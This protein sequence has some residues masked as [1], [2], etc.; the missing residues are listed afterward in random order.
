MQK[1]VTRKVRE[2]VVEDAVEGFYLLKSPTPRTTQNGKNYLTFRLADTSGEIE[3]IYWDYEG[4]LHDTCAGKP[5]KVRGTISEYNGKKQFN[6]IQIRAAKEDDPLDMNALIPTAPIDPKE[7]YSQLVSLLDTIQ[8]PE[9]KKLCVEMLARNQ[10]FIC[11]IP[12]AKSVHHSFRYGLLMHTYFMMCHADYMSRFYPFVNRDL[13][14]AGTFCHDL[15]KSKEYELSSF[16]LVTDY[17]VSGH[18]LGHLY[19]GAL[20]VAK[21]SSEL[22]ISEEKSM[23]LQHM[24]LSHHGK[25][26]YGAAVAPQTAEAVLLSMIDDL[27]AKMELIRETLEGQQ[28]GMT[29]SVWALGNRL[30]QHD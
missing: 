20:E 10:E 1:Y 7:T 15:A 18:L 13:L 25:P 4:D 19:M 27:D 12:A 11:C 30:Y 26:E 23:L 6:I 5:V 8:D 2:M 14:L 28:P 3:G 21:V 17:T 29:D 24:L 16:G 22:G 9:Y